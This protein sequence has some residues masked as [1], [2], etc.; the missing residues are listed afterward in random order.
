ME[1][2]LRQSL[3]MSQGDLTILVSRPIAAVI[4]ALAALVLLLPLLKQITVRTQT[5]E[6]GR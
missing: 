3:M 1:R 4:L 6:S 2:A 5:I